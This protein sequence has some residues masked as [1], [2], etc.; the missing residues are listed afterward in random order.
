MLKK[1]FIFSLILALIITLVPLFSATPSQAAP[2]VDLPEQAGIYDIPGNPHLKLRVFV[3]AANNQNYGKPTSSKGKPTPPPPSE[4][5]RPTSTADPD[6]LAVVAGA[7]WTLPS[8]W[9]YNLNLAS[10]PAT[11]GSTN[12]T[13]IT[14]NAFDVWLSIPTVNQSVNIVRGNDTTVVKAQFDS[15]NIIA[16]GRTSGSALAVSYIWY[17]TLTHVATEIDTIMNKSF[18][19]YWSNPANWPAGQTC[20]YSGVYDAQNILTHELGHTIGLDDEYTSAYIN[21][22]M[23]GYGSTGETK[24]NTLTTG[25]KTGVGN[26]Y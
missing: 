26:L 23:Y 15:S 14:D 5:C 22:T 4:T 18:T 19:W 17:N 11:I 3:H 10:I 20:A 16:W 2:N 21:N 7:G 6:S 1:H 8:T 12:L 24:K 25:D 13:T 9:T